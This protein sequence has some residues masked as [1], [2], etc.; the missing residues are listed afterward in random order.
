MTH[1]FFRHGIHHILVTGYVV[2]AIVNPIQGKRVDEITHVYATRQSGQASFDLHL[3][4]YRNVHR[5]KPCQTLLIHMDNLK[6]VFVF[7]NSTLFFIHFAKVYVRQFTV[8]QDMATRIKLRRKACIVVFL[9]F[10]LLIPFF[11]MKVDA[12]SFQK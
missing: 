3:M 11:S 1:I 7:K 6:G 9:L 8:N 2:L 12:T 10:L 5:Y 4:C